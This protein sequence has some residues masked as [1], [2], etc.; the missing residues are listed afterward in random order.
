MKSMFSADFLIYLTVLIIALAG[1]SQA[2]FEQSKNR[3]GG[4]ATSGLY[5]F[6]RVGRS[7]PSLTNNLHDMDDNLYE[8]S[9]EDYEGRTDAEMRKW[10]RLLALQQALEKRAGPTSGLWF[11]PR[12]GKRSVNNNVKQ[13]ANKG[14]NEEY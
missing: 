12:L 11:G 3:R 1:L 8:P 7:D 13:H 14:Q 5:A 4:G 6:P 9:L 2:E 10:A